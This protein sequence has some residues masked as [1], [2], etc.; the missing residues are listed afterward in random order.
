MIIMQD[1]A[2]SVGSRTAALHSGMASGMCRTRIETN[3][4]QVEIPLDSCVIQDG[5]VFRAEQGITDLTRSGRNQRIHA[6]S[7]NIAQCGL[8]KQSH[9]PKKEVRAPTQTR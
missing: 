6:W 9:K 3:P 5:G 2:E 1:A 8:Y 4:S 7:R